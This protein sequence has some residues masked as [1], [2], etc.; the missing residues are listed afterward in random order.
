M[1]VATSVVAS[2]CVNAF[3]FLKLLVEK[4]DKWAQLAFSVVYKHGQ[5]VP[6]DD[7]SIEFKI[8]IGYSHAASE[9][10]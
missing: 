10:T 6:E 3:Q 8:T 5:G 9:L 2:D 4:G 7:T 1:L